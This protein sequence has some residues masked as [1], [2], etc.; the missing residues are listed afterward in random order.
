MSTPNRRQKIA[1]GHANVKHPDIFVGA[2]FPEEKQQIVQSVIN[3]AISKGRVLRYSD[4]RVSFWNGSDTVIHFDPNS[5]DLGTIFQ[6][7]PGN[8]P[9]YW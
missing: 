1:A 9:K 7:P 2:I 4:G 3:E 8:G 5:K 6:T